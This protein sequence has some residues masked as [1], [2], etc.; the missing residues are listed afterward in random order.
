M[1]VA[2]MGFGSIE[3]TFLR[4]AD[5]RALPV[6]SVA[7]PKAIRLVPVERQQRLAPGAHLAIGLNRA[8]VYGD[9]TL[10]VRA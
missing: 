8:F 3:S 10:A 4:L 2:A 7:T 9:F 5:G 1:I 6:I